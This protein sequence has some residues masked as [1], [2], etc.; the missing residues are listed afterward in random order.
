MNVV[1]YVYTVQILSTF[2]LAVYSNCPPLLRAAH[3]RP[4]FRSYFEF[5]GF[6]LPVYCGT[7]DVMSRKCHYMP[8]I[9]FVVQVQNSCCIGICSLLVSNLI[10]STI[11]RF[12]FHMRTYLLC[13]CPI[14]ITQHHI[15]HKAICFPRYSKLS[16][17]TWVMAD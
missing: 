9:S 3:S 5:H 16:P 7:L 8:S 6:L 4:C 13:L 2:K 15:T 1:T 11:G 12:L 17:I 10:P 14:K